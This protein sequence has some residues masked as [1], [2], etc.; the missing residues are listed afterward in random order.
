MVEARVKGEKNVHAG[1]RKR[2]RKRFI[3]QGLESM[4]PHEVFELLLTF[5]IPRIDVNGTAH[6]IINSFEGSFV[7]AL[8]ADYA[9]LREVDGVGE[10]AA[11]LIRFVSEFGRYSGSKESDARVLSNPRQIIDFLRPRFAN[12]GHEEL[13][14]LCL[15]GNNRLLSA[16]RV[17]S[18][19]SCWTHVDICGVTRE[20][21]RANAGKVVLAHNHP[22]GSPAPSDADRVT[23]NAIC[24]ALDAVRVKLHDHIIFAGDRGVS[25]AATNIY[26]F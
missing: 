18:G 24:Q 16:R 26:D 15:T 19:S 1:H 10:N 3:E 7:N 21:V 17:A 9:R 8:N 13:H 11:A 23:N 6:R 20:A 4:E 22:D 2:L 25:M 5:A 14:M 12:L